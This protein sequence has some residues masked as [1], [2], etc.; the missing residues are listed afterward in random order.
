MKMKSLII[1]L[2]LSI[3]SF[4][5]F[6]IEK[7]E[8]R[9]YCLEKV[10]DQYGWPKYSISPN[11]KFTLE[12][13]YHYYDSMSLYIIR[14][15]DTLNKIHIMSFY[16]QDPRNLYVNIFNVKVDYDGQRI[17][18]T[19]S[20][21]L[22]TI[23][24]TASGSTLNSGLYNTE[25]FAIDVSSITSSEDKSKKVNAPF[26]NF[27]VKNSPNLFNY[28]TSIQYS[29]PKTNYVAI[30]IFNRNGDLLTV[31][32]QKKRKAGEYT[33]LWDG[34]DNSGKQMSCG[35]YFYQV[36]SGDYISSKRMFLL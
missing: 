10:Y 25:G 29:I 30:N 23:Y 7:D 34:K 26:N 31:L 33:V 1:L 8:L 9:S 6:P 4:G 20:N 24:V 13:V 15:I 32:E 2:L 35:E 3:F 11:N 5:D 27:E 28:S 22:D 14:G 36:V 16:P 12:L 21:N 17:F 19:W 18:C